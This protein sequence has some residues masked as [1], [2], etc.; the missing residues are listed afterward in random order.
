[1]AGQSTFPTLATAHVT[2]IS[3]KLCVSL[4]A[5]NGDSLRAGK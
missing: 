2:L 5:R 3:V 4:K 1:V